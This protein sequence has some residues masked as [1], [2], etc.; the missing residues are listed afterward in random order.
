[1]LGLPVKNL[2]PTSIR[3]Q[4]GGNQAKEHS[5]RGSVTR[6]PVAV[7]KVAP[8]YP[9]EALDAG[10]GGNVVVKIWVRKDGKPGHVSILKSDAEVLNAPS[11]EA[12][13]GFEFTPAYADSVPVA[14][15]VSVPFTFY[16]KG[17]EVRSK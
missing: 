10:I 15:W 6:E 11:I 1:M 4:E 2:S 16:P 14:V 8:H 9:Q 7:K 13:M 5:P 12:A 3:V 17:K